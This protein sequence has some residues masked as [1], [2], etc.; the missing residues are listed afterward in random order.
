[1]TVQ[2]EDTVGFGEIYWVVVWFALLI[3]L[4]LYVDQ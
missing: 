3:V 4:L 1:M 2:V